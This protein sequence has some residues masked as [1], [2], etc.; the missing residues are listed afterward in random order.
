M[1]NHHEDSVLFN[2]PSAIDHSATKGQ[3][4]EAAEALC[5]DPRANTALPELIYPGVAPALGGATEPGFPRDIN[6]WF[7]NEAIAAAVGLNGSA[8]FGADFHAFGGKIGVTPSLLNAPQQQE[9]VALSEGNPFRAL[10]N[11]AAPANGVID[12]KRRVRLT[13]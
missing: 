2:Q 1:A 7:G 11:R 3:D 4:N 9:E 6:S 5:R 12:F 13:D 8:P 10:L